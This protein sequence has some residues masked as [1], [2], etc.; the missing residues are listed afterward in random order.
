[1]RTKSL[2]LSSSG[3]KNIVLGKQQEE[4][5]EFIFNEDKIH[6]KTIFAEFISPKVSKI[7]QVDPTIDSICFSKELKNYQI[8]KDLLNKFEQLTKGDEIQIRETEVPELEI[9]SILIENDELYY[10]VQEIFEEEQSENNIDK[11]I[12]HMLAFSRLP[13]SDAYL[14]EGKTIDFLA[15][16]FY[17]IDSDKLIQL[18]RDIIYSIISNKHLKIESEDSLFEII[19]Q[20]FS[21]KECAERLEDDYLNITCFYEEFELAFLS[22]DRFRE[23]IEIIDPSSITK[24]LWQK[25]K[26]CFYINKKQNVLFAKNSSMRYFSFG[27]QF[28]YNGNNPL[29]GIVDYKKRS[30]NGSFKATSS[31]EMYS[32]SFAANASDL[33]NSNNCFESK[34]EQNSWLKYDFGSQKVHPTHY[35]IRTRHDSNCHHLRNWVIEGANSDSN[36]ENEWK[37]LD[38]RLNDTFL[39]NINAVHT[40][41]IGKIKCYECYRYLRIRQTGV[42]SDNSNYLFI[43]ALE[44]F[45]SLI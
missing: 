34:D 30:N 43:S 44:F 20:I 10:K 11:Y 29:E 32:N 37:I 40:Y 38:S 35:S 7:H 27:Q 12:D 23:L 14:K 33:H 4:E 13:M 36:N 45:G 21:N 9:I 31:S 3:L 26:C 25:L 2:T 16:Y 6:M 1:M 39:N 42:N 17:L 28:S 18:R 8:S 5:F 22:E 15:S 19:K 24:N 41:E